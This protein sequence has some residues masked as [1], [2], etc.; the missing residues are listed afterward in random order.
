MI[1]VLGKKPLKYDGVKYIST[2]S[3]ISTQKWKKKWRTVADAVWDNKFQCALI[4]ERS[5]GT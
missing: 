1:S 3:G 5:N 4:R 2:V